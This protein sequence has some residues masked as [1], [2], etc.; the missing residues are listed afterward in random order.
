MK[1]LIVLLMLMTAGCQSN[2]PED[3]A[4]RRA[5]QAQKQ[6]EKASRDAEKRMAQAQARAEKQPMNYESRSEEMQKRSQRE[7]EKRAEKA[8]EK[9]KI[10]PVQPEQPAVETP[11]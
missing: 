5:Q 4:M 6:Y 1:K 7:M 2:D 9:I 3:V 8:D 11:E 10:E